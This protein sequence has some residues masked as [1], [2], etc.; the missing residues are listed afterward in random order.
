[1]LLENGLGFSTGKV[2]LLIIWRPLAFSIT[3]PLGAYLTV[4]TGERLSGVT[5]ALIVMLS[6][7]AL[8]AIG[9]GTTEL[10]IGFALALSGIGLGLSAPAMTATVAGAVDLD[11]LGV[12]GATQQLIVQVG[13]VAGIQVMQTVQKAT[14]G[15]RGL[16]E[17][18]GV[19]Y[20]VGAGACLLAAVCALF[21][22]TNPTEL[23][24]RR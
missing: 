13:T 24:V 15:T 23:R 17:S 21:V 19:A 20:Y 18:F 5:G 4:R 10:F 1:M 3:A 11:D 16:I 12:A 14:E 7:F 6:M 22:R 2:G 9:V 8:A